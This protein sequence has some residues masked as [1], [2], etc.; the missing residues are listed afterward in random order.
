MNHQVYNDGI[1]REVL[2]S[3]E[4]GLVMHGKLLLPAGAS[5]I[6]IIG[7]VSRNNRISNNFKVLAQTIRNRHIGT[8]LLHLSN[9]EKA[10]DRMLKFDIECLARRLLLAKSWLRNHPETISL[11]IAYLSAGMG[12]G[13]ALVAASREPAN[14]YAVVS[15]GGRPDLAANFLRDVKTPTLFIVGEKDA[16]EIELNNEARDALRQATRVEIISGASHLFEESGSLE[17]AAKLAAD[18]FALYTKEGE[19]RTA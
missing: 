7:Q 6:V 19:Q 5:A 16:D 12:A 8:L 4:Q 15:C 11:R 17:R 13:A 18:W 3:G 1:E 10:E 2:I 9:E 14:V